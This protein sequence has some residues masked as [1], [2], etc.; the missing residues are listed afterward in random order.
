MERIN[1]GVVLTTEEGT[2]QSASST[3][4]QLVLMPAGEVVDIGGAPG[5][6]GVARG[7]RWPW[8]WRA[9]AT[10]VLGHHWQEGRERVGGGGVRLGR[11]GRRPYL[12]QGQGPAR[13]VP[14]LGRHGQL[15]EGGGGDPGSWLGCA[16]W[17][18]G[19]SCIVVFSFIFFFTYVF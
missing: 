4:S 1:G 7:G 9:A 10:N 2:A 15:E 18:I 11:P 3:V 17:P 14:V 12:P 8:Q 6:I 5:Q 19:P 13:T 16:P